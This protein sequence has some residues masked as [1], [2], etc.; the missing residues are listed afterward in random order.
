LFDAVVPSLA[1]E[2]ARVTLPALVAAVGIGSSGWLFG[3]SR[4]AAALLL[5]GLG[6]VLAAL[7][8]D[9]VAFPSLHAL[10]ASGALDVGQVGYRVVRA[11]SNLAEGAGL[12]CAALA[13]WW[14]AGRDT[15]EEP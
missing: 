8:I 10:A 5:V 14:G 12:A 7:A 1:A 13:G 2:L 4:P 9:V 15:E 3:R 6:L 11:L